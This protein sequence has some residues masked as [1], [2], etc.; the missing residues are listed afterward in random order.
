MRRFTRFAC[1][2]WSGAAGAQQKGIALAVCET[3]EEAPRLVPPPARYWSR[4]S[5]LD[6]LLARAEEQTD[7]IV[8]VDFS[9]ALPFDGDREGGGGYFPGLADM[10]R[11][12]R[13]LWRHVDETCADDPHLGAGHYVRHGDLAPFFRLGATTGA[14]F[15]SADRNGR[16]RMVEREAGSGNPASCFNLVG[17][18]Q[19][20]LSSLTGM[21]VLHRLAGRIPVWPFDDIPVGGPLIVEI[22]TSIAALAAGRA[23]GR[24]KM[25]TIEAMNAALARLGSAPAPGSGAIDDHASDAIVTAAWLRLAAADAALW[26]P[27]RLAAVRDTEGWTFGVP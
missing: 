22:Y 14:R 4:A 9:A 24:A 21:R 17:A 26:S 2:D 20:G 8:G 10:P 19:V 15:A 5:I 12:A 6:W 18:K 13:A 1:I 27:P 11:D 25:R 7:M 23:K 16:L 3:G